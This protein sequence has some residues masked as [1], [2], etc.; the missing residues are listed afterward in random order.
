ME[1]YLKFGESESVVGEDQVR[2]GRRR[3]QEDRGDARAAKRKESERENSRR[4]QE[5]DDTHEETSTHTTVT[6]CLL[7]YFL[8]NRI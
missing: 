8:I 1:L 5:V 6:V 2:V 4:G 7:I 3:S